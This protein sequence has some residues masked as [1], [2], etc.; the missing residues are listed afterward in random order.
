MTENLKTLEVPSAGEVLSKGIDIQFKPGVDISEVRHAL[1]FIGG[2]RFRTNSSVLIPPHLASQ[3]IEEVDEKKTRS[4]A[5]SRG[6]GET[7][8]AKSQPKA[9]RKTS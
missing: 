3:I 5:A 4:A 8:S 2:M 7:A 6:T 1:D 9:P